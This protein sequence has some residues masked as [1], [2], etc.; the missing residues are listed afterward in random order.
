MQKSYT[1]KESNRRQRASSLN[2]KE[3]GV[4]S[5]N[6]ASD[7]LVGRQPVLEALKSGRSMNKIILAEGAEGGSLKEIIGKAKSAG[8]VLQTA[9]RA[10]LQAYGEN[11]QGIVAFV[12]PYSYVELEDIVKR[13]TGY[14]PLVVLLDE[15]SD[16]HNLG[17]ILRTAEATGV[18]G[19]IIPKRRAVPLTGTVAKAAAGALE[20][21][22]V[23]RVTNLVQAMEWLKEHG[24][25]I[26]GTSIGATAR[27]SD[28]DMRGKTAIVIGAEDKGL[29]RLVAERCDFMVSLPML[30]HMQSLNASVAAGV[31]L[32]EA[33]RQRT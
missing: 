22:P 12:S 24:Y 3:V 16:P 10:S 21:M 20:Y 32:Y 14:A 2:K 23:S 27:P 1:G 25:W 31:L 11:H 13:D 26:V 18:Q 9:P 17:A 8:V 28:V 19:V 33:V 15:L 30:G 4:L 7:V 29:G 6:E 5:E